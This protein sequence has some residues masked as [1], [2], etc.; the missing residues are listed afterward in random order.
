MQ[1]ACSN[2]RVQIMKAKIFFSN[3]QIVELDGL[4]SLDH[5][6]NAAQVLACR[7]SASYGRAVHVE[8]VKMDKDNFIFN[9]N[10]DYWMENVTVVS[11][12]GGWGK[13]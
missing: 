7:Y 4:R 6:N 3:N 12:I 2:D 13:A 10:A 11:S 1:I 9:P 5:A 8:S